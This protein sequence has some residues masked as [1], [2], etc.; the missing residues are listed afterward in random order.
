ML[1]LDEP[2][3]ALDKKLREETQFEL[4]GLQEALGLTFVVVTHDQEEAMT[5]A[6]RISVMDH[7][8]V[9]QVAPPGEI[10]EAPNSRYVADFI[11]SVN[12]FEGAVE[13]AGPGL[14]RIAAVDGVTIQADTATE[15]TIGQTAWFALRPEKVRIAHAP[16]AD[17]DGINTVAGEVPFFLGFGAYRHHVPASVDHLIQ[18]G[19]FLTAYTPYQPEIAQGTLQMLFEFQTQVARLLGTDVAN[20]SMYDGSTASSEAWFGSPWIG[21]SSRAS[22]GTSANRSSIDRAPIAASIAVRSPG[23]RDR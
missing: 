10:Y 8:R 9:V 15:P 2:L 7:G 23:V 6:D 18:R 22:A 17:A 14:V 21:P 1:L 16:P 3:G 4:I 11:G 13:A 5:M 19:E 12:L 20:A